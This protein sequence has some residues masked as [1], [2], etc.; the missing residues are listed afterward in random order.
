MKALAINGGNPVRTKQF[1]AWPAFDH[2]EEK[3]LLKVLRS[4]KWWRF[5]FGQGVEL[6]EPEKGERSQVALFQE[7]FAR[8]HDCKYGIA[9]ANGTGTLE[10]GIRAMDLGIGDEIIV[11]AYTYVAS[12]TCVLQN[13]LLP[14]FV[15]MDPDTYNIDPRRIEEAI[16][17]K[18]RA[19]MVVHFGGQPADMDRIMA[20][21]R[22]HHL[23]VIE[24]AAHAHGCEWQG[25]KAG[26]FGLFSSFSFQ[27]AKNMTSGEG[28]MICTD[29][30]K[31]A[32]ECESM[33]WSGRH[34]GRPWYE[35]H[36]LGWN[37]RL[38]EFQAAILR[39]QLKR[40]DGQNRQRM[41]NANYLSRKLGQIE[42]IR[43]L[44]QDPRTTM[45]GYHIYMFRYDGKITG[46]K[47]DVFLRALAAEGIPVFSGYTFPLYQ[48][49]MFLKKRFINGSFPLGT[50][51]HKDIDYA[52][53]EKK[54][55]VAE[56]ACK[57]EAVW[58]AQNILLGT[59]ADM[60]DIV[61]AIKKVL[62]HKN[63]LK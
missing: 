63:E 52:S 47:R 45:H 3:A 18:T 17:N 42:G 24:D 31:L 28:G 51:Y 38:T 55:P 44:V 20:I 53:F 37:Y 16:T 39:C 2:T 57:K 5:A 40:L 14:V 62:D 15:D 13:N 43:P 4:G 25:K 26:S 10:M 61:K 41:K 34:V 60:E 49:P 56:R 35:F 36:R 9:A 58:L 54:C 22:K 6:A 8:K 32:T 33:M 7:E 48:N 12:A 19:I 27:A 23:P 59:E 11:P 29:D 50:K 46:L 21:A 30:R 1:P